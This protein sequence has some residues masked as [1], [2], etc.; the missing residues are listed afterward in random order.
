MAGVFEFAAM[1]EVACVRERRH[2]LVVDDAR[3]PSAMVE[4]QMRVHD[5]IDLLRLESAGGKLR[6][7]SGRA[8]KCIN[9]AAFVV[10]FIARSGFH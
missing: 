8:F 1:D 7:Q 3:I 2:R 6:R 5:D 10:P 9:V 4:M